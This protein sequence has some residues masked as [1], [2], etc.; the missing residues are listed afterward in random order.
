[1]AGNP[2]LTSEP[3]P[4]ATLKALQTRFKVSGIVNISLPSHFIN[5]ACLNNLLPVSN[6]PTKEALALTQNKTCKSSETKQRHRLT[7]AGLYKS[8]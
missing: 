3:F 4:Q 7:D 1:M 2:F 6:I 5:S 8:G